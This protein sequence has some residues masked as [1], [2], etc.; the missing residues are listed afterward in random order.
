ML[1]S[2]ASSVTG[3]GLYSASIGEFAVSSLW[4]SFQYIDLHVHVCISGRLWVWLV[5][6]V[7][8]YPS[9]HTQRLQMMSYRQKKTIFRSVCCVVC[10]CVM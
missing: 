4:S 7:C 2:A 5:N 3:N 6:A 9:P 8:H 1:Q 10:L